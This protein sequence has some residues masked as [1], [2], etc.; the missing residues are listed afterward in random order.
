MYHKEYELYMKR[1][2]DSFVDMQSNKIYGTIGHDNYSVFYE[3]LWNGGLEYKFGLN[4]NKVIK[5]VTFEEMKKY[6]ANVAKAYL[7]ANTLSYDEYIKKYH[8]V[9]NK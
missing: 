7:K 3:V 5:G 9:E 8:N 2:T 1:V 4:G 6:N